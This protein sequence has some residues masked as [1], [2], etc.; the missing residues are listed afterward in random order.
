MLS[1]ELGDL[2]VPH[3]IG[4]FCV[5]HGNPS[6]HLVQQ[7]WCCCQLGVHKQ[8]SG[9]L[10]GVE[11]TAIAPSRSLE[12]SSSGQ[13]DELRLKNQAATGPVEVWSG[14]VAMWVL[15]RAAG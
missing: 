15:P 10:P 9:V 4:A 1:T 14:Q 8:C 13:L 5:L 12:R 6:T 7:I 2:D 3:D 11:L